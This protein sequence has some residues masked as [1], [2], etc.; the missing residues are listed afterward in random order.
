MSTAKICAAAVL[1]GVTGCAVGP[2][3]RAPAADTPEH[4]V[5]HTGMAGSG[6]EAPAPSPDLSTWWREPGDTQLN[7][8]VEPAIKANP[9]PALSPTRVQP[10]RPSP[11][12][13]PRH[14]PPP[15]HGTPPPAPRP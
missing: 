3:Y 10:A 5:S 9:D 12:V 1:C 8:L 14:A 15:A 11:P 2:S 4:Y 7:S 6:P 13:G